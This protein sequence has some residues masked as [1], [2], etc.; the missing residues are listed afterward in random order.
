MKFKTT[1]KQ[2]NQNYR[3]VICIGYCDAQYLLNGK[4]PIAY[5]SGVYGWN[6]DVYDI[7]G[8][9]I[10][11]GYRPWGNI[12]PDYNTIKK[13][14]DDAREICGKSWGSLQNMVDQLD[15]LLDQFIEEVTK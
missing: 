8:V 11:T 13:Y 14:E 12:H 9:A 7:K 6:C 2:I 3:R 15:T 10:V 4:N 1:R 5:N